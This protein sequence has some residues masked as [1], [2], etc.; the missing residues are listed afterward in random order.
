MPIEIES[1]EQL[2]YGKI[3]CNLAE[4]SVTEVTWNELGFTPVNFPL[5]YG[6]HKGKPELRELIAKK[7]EGITAEDVLLVPGAAAALFIV[8]TTLCEKDDHV[9]VQFPNYATNLETP[10]AIG[11]AIDT[12]ELDFENG[13][14]M[15]VEELE[16]RVHSRTKMISV[17]TPH[18]PSGVMLDEK[19]LE[20]AIAIAE[21]KN[22][23]LLADETYRDLA[24]GEAP[25]LAGTLSQQAIS[26]SSI[27]KAYGLPGLRIGWI[28]TRNEAL[29][30]TFLAAKEQIFICNS[31]LDEEAAFHF[32]QKEKNWL[33]RT[34]AHVAENFAHVERWIASQEQLEWVKPEGGAVCFPRFR[35]SAGIDAVEFHERLFRE[36]ATYVGPGHWFGMNDRYMRIGFG[37]P[38][39]GELQEGLNAMSEVMRT[40]HER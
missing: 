40:F 12:V 38:S 18:N 24:F 27:S 3:R 35:E 30:E 39:P 36:H 15:D 26:V 28:I 31:V 9:L 19:T 11:C 33:A 17:T 22:I 20:A 23:F 10:F 8:A 25:R 14:R 37:W 16:Q 13:F 32:L 2:G 4:S 1:P 5:A 29:M 34:R 7:Y 21:R 6:D